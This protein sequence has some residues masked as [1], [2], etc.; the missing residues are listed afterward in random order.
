MGLRPEPLGSEG[1]QPDARSGLLSDSGAE[2]RR[3]GQTCKQG[4]GQCASVLLGLG[5]W[6]AESASGDH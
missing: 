5:P 1:S 4:V 2:G 3:R 6:H